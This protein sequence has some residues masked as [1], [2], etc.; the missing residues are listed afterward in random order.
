M[1]NKPEDG[2]CRAVTGMV[3]F[4]SL[5]ILRAVRCGKDGRLVRHKDLPESGLHMCPAHEVA[6]INA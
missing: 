2:P 1:I 6:R 5:Q 3:Q 4:T